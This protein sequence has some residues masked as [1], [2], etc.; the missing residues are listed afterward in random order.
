MPHSLITT[1]LPEKIWNHGLRDSHITIH[2]HRLDRSSA[3]PCA[4][5]SRHL[6][7]LA[8]LGLL[9]LQALKCLFVPFFWARM[10]PVTLLLDPMLYDFPPQPACREVSPHHLLPDPVMLFSVAFSHRMHSFVED[11]HIPITG[12]APSFPLEDELCGIW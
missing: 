6:R 3:L 7:W 9:A 4:L 8:T 2:F 5:C 10:L 1:Y 12:P 11:H